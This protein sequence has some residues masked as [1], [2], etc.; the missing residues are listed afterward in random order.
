MSNGNPIIQVE[1]LTKQYGQSVGIDRINFEVNAG[2]I[3]G[4]LGPTGAGKTTTIR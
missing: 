2:E 4:F 3:F 1:Q